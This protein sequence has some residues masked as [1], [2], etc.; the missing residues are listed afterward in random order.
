MRSYAVFYF[1][2]NIISHMNFLPLESREPFSYSLTDHKNLTCVNF[3]TQRVI[4]WY[5]V[6]EEFAPEL[7]YITSATNVV[8]DATSCLVTSDTIELNTFDLIKTHDMFVF[9]NYM[10]NSKIDK[11]TNYESSENTPW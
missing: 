11:Q 3:N 2:S 8:A 5:M 7:V 4:C 9:A 1:M 10:A 6:I